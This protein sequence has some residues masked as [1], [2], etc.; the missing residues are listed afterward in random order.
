MIKVTPYLDFDQDTKVLKDRTNNAVVELSYSEAAI[1]AYLL[2]TR[3]EI[4]TKEKL[5]EVGWPDRVVAATS[6]PQC[7]STLRKKLDPYTEV[8]LKTIARRGY[9]LHVTEKSHVTMVSMSDPKSIK[10]ALIDVSLLVKVMG[11]LVLLAI[12]AWVWYHSDYH[13]V[14]KKSAVWDTS[15]TVPITLREVEEQLPL[16]HTG[17]EQNLHPSMWQKHI[18]PEANVK[19]LF[20]SF[21]GFALADNQLYSFAAC[22]DV[23][24]GKCVGKQL[25][26]MAM[27]AQEP[28]GLNM[29]EFDQLRQI[30]EERIR[31]NRELIPAGS[32]DD[33]EIEE[34]H[35]HA[36]VYFPVAN[37]LLVRADLGISL[38]YE[39]PLGG[40]FYY[41]ACITDQDCLTTP[42]K[43]KVRGE[44]QQYRQ[45]LGDYEVDVF[46][47]KS[48]QKNLIRPE[49]VSDSAMYFYRE[50]RKHNVRDEEMFFYRVSH[51]HNSAVWIMPLF[52]NVVTWTHYEKVML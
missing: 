8:Q 25:M 4:V 28:A 11:I 43:Y 17:A 1:F 35:Y 36:D 5:L 13:S 15:S 22:L 26:N 34:H 40:K 32:V 3:D 48:L 44:F 19:G 38:V 24:D 16:F 2:E 23:E 12:V 46:H 52:E 27:I 39:Q 6:L 21:D 41:S 9:Q 47:V 29:I 33:G 50:I 45:T 42:I 30:M 14:V 51:T 31:Y 20:E 18:A 7:I 10:A 49:N 37:K